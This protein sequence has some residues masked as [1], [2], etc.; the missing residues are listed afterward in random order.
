VQA[1]LHWWGEQ[2]EGLL[3]YLAA[4]KGGGATYPLRCSPKYLLRYV[5]DAATL[6]VIIEEAA[7]SGGTRLL[8]SCCVGLA[9]M[10]LLTPLR[11]TF[12]VLDDSDRLVGT[13]DVALWVHYPGVG[14]P[15][16]LQ[17]Q[18][19]APPLGGTM[20]LQQQQQQQQQQEQH[21]SST[22]GLRTA[23]TEAATLSGQVSTASP[24]SG[25]RRSSPGP[26]SGAHAAPGQGKENG[27]EPE[28][29]VSHRLVCASACVVG[30]EA[31][32]CLKYAC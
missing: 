29:H 27:A 8:G 6:V 15:G 26:A 1:R 21:H 18:P 28:E 17:Q 5:H 13:I 19:E 32:K 22:P 20:P 4:G 23:P 25:K 30:R 3:A 2:G 10:D 24:P 9:D 16:I 12:P 14:P 7:P 31:G 11:G